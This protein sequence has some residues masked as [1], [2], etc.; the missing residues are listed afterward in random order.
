LEAIR[1]GRV[2]TLPPLVVSPD[3]SIVVGD[4][5]WDTRTGRELFQNQFAG[6]TSRVVFSADGKSLMALT[7]RLRHGAEGL[8]VWELA[9]GGVRRTYEKAGFVINSFTR[10]PQGKYLAVGGEDGTLR[11]WEAATG[12]ELHAF[13]GGGAPLQFTPDGRHL[14]SRSSHC[15]LLVWDVSRWVKE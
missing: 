2:A 14:V 9:T 6:A 1:P 5:F 7:S 8:V 11:L 3:G 12:K 10:S 13:A 15:D 4:R